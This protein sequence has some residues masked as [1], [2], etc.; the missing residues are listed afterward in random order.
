A[1]RVQQDG[2]K[3][4]PGPATIEIKDASEIRVFVDLRTNYTLDDPAS[5]AQHTLRAA[6]GRGADSILSDHISDYQHLFQRV[7]FK[8]GGTSIGEG[9]PTDLRLQRVRNRQPDPGFYPLFF[10]YN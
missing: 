7:H 4:N 5:T 10:Q 1:I 2:G 3:I 8:L 6:I 9:L